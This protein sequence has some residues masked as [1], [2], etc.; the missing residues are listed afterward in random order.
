MTRSPAIVVLTE[1]GRTLAERLRA[2]LPGAAVH[3]LDRRVREADVRFDDTINHLARLYASGTPIVGICAAG[4]LIRAIAPLLS[5]KR[6]EPPL[7]AIA[8]D[9]SAVVPL[10]GGHRGG[11][12]LAR[13]IANALGIA[14]ALTTAGDL[15]FGVAL[16]DPPPGWTLANP[17]AAKTLMA[18]RLAGTPVRLSV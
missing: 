5:D 11:N 1:A 6:A 18:A 2:S 13:K 9:G 7:L 10:L 17:N 16:D 14:P 12:A 3:A 8:E 4:I 15:A